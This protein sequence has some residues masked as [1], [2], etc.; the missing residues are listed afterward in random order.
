MSRV[1]AVVDRTVE[2]YDEQRREVVQAPVEQVARAQIRREGGGW[3]YV[4]MYSPDE[5]R[6]LTAYVSREVWEAVKP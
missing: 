4:L 1:E 3:H 2:F 5:A 6:R